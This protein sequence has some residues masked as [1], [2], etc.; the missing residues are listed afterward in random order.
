MKILEIKISFSNEAE[1]SIFKDKGKAREYMEGKSTLKELRTF[2][3]QEGKDAK[4]EPRTGG[5]N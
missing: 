5:V 2:F 3:N 1:I 4:R